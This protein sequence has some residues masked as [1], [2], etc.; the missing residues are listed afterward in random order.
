MIASFLEKIGIQQPKKTTTH[1]DS[2]LWRITHNKAYDLI[3]GFSHRAITDIIKDLE[4]YLDNI[5]NDQKSMLI[6]E[7][8][9]E[10]IRLIANHECNEVVE[11]SDLPQEAIEE[12]VDGIAMIC[13]KCKYKEL[14]Y[15][16]STKD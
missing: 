8:L 6:G 7:D 5:K 11:V 15:R 12:I 13:F 2:V 14:S 3:Y 4:Q 10:F 9:A 16:L 1:S